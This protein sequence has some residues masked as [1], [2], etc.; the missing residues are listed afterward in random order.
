MIR[1]FLYGLAAA[2]FFAVT[3]VLNRSMSLGGGSWMWSAA[4]RFLFTLPLL[5]PVLIWTGELP[6]AWRHFRSA[7]KEYLL[8]GTVGFGF[9][10]APL[11]FAGDYGPGWL[12]ASSWQLT[13]ICGSLL[14]PWL[15]PGARIP[16]ANLRWSLLVVFGVALMQWRQLKEFSSEHVLLCLAPVVLAAFMYPLGNRKMMSLCAGRVST[17]ARVFNMTLGSLPFW[18]FLSL[19]ATIF[20]GPPPAGQMIQALAVALFAGV[21]ATVLFFSATNQVRHDFSKL[22]AIE[23]TQAL[24]VLF[25]LGGEIFFLGAGLPDGWSLA[26]IALVTGGVM[27]N[28]LSAARL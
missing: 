8:W 7:W 26:G 4:L 16:W 15:Q 18:L 21:I 6:S 11:V 17:P 20:S 23:A 28:S 22:A 9:F 12:V 1:P 27:L 10:Y 2:L 5:L 13:I 24:E 19:Q 25:A 3:F 14:L